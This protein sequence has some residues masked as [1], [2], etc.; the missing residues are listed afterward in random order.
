MLSTSECWIKKLDLKNLCVINMT[1]STYHANHA[2][3]SDEELERRAGVKE[4]ELKKIFAAIPF[5]PA[6]GTVRIAVIGC[7]DARYVA[8]HKR[9][10]EKLLQMPVEL[11]TFDITV[12]HL[13]GADGIA[14]HD[15]TMPLPNGP[16]DITFG[17]VLL[18][19]IETEKQWDALLCSYQAL[20]APGLAIH[21]F[22]D[23]DITTTTVLQKDGRYSVPLEWW[24]K[25]LEEQKILYK[26][27]H[28]DMQ[29]PY[30]P[31]GIRGLKG[32]ALVLVK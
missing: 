5:Q 9:I 1:L 27:L 18:K 29:L 2:G 13:Q 23:E 24:K 10:F 28:W 26:E 20:R 7:V 19:F 12:E 22:D 21:V 11:T 16:Y 15:V 17:H 30:L 32:G 25:K 31:I 8:H 6:A 3:R 4:E 14:E